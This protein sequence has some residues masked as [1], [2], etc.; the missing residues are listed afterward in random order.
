MRID[1]SLTARKLG[2]PR[3][4]LPAGICLHDTAGTGTHNDTLYLSNPG[5]GRAVSVDFT[6]ER[7]GTI[8][9]LNPDIDLYFTFHA[10][11]STYFKI[12]GA[13]FRN[14]ECNRALIGIELVQR[15]DLKLQP[16]WPAEQVRSAAELC[17]M[18]LAKYKLPKERI[19]T[20][21]KIITDG[22]RSDPRQFPFADFWFLFNRMANT[23]GINPPPAAGIAGP[24]IYEVA[25]GD[26]LFAIAK[27]FAVTIEDIKHLNGINEA[28]NLIVPGQK[29]IL[30]K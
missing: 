9:Q 24:T 1:R 22:T 12:P 23:P 21:S 10:G 26:S 4:I 2:K 11:R 8:F 5:D 25:A 14:A 7:D 28:S 17:Y 29:L 3:R 6:I 18:L 27:R 19:T 16:I 20:H 30:K 13:A 15:A